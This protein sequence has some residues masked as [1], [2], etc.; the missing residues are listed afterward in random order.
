MIKDPKKVLD[1]ILNYLMTS[2]D[3]VE[4]EIFHELKIILEEG[5]RILSRMEKLEKKLDSL[6]EEVTRN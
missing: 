6:L 4:E 2:D 5:H 3:G 1:E